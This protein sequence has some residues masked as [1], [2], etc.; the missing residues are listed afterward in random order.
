MNCQYNIPHMPGSPE[1][2]LSLSYAN[3]G[4][5]PFSAK[6][7]LSEACQCS[8]RGDPST[9]TG[10]TYFKPVQLKSLQHQGTTP[11]VGRIT[12]YKPSYQSLPP[13][14]KEKGNR[15][16][17]VLNTDSTVVVSERHRQRV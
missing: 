14:V 9:R 1:S 16:F 5:Y 3:S 7:H 13:T 17:G 12:V 10:Q 8:E 2:A 15:K 4:Q 11:D 6:Q